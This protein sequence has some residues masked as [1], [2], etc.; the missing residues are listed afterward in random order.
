MWEAGYKNAVA[1]YINYIIYHIENSVVKCG[2]RSVN[3]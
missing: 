1:S 3:F 2:F